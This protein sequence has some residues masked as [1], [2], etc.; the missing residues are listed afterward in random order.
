MSSSISIGIDLIRR[1]LF[2][3][4]ASS[5]AITA[6]RLLLKRVTSQ[7][8]NG[9]VDSDSRSPV[10]IAATLILPPSSFPAD[11]TALARVS[12]TPGRRGLN[13]VNRKA[14][15]AP[16]PLPPPCSKAPGSKQ[17]TLTLYALSPEPEFDG[18]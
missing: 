6:P 14:E 12:T 1:G 16:P 15:Y 10:G 17:H 7:R 9:R 8:R 11:T 3:P 13:T 18:D 2:G 5:S 4:I